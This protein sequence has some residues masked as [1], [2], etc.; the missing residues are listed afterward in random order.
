MRLKQITETQITEKATNTLE[1]ALNQ[2]TVLTAEPSSFIPDTSA[3][4]QVVGLPE[5]EAFSFEEFT[6]FGGEVSTAALS[7]EAFGIITAGIDPLEITPSGAVITGYV[8][9]S[10]RNDIRLGTYV[11]VSY[12]N[13]EKLFAKVEKLQYRQEFAVDDA[14]EIH[15]RRIR[16]ARANPIN[17]ADYKFLPALIP[18]AFCTERL[19]VHSHEEW[20]TE[21]LA[22]IPLSCLGTQA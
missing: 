21:F 14:T 19:T 16:N 11:L 13:E 6:G 17:E 7:S 22:P 1:S 15:S 20:Q 4:S 2:A 18:Y 10:R 12:G 5:K 3:N 9:S 8:T